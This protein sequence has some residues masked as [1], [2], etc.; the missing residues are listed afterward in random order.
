MG[1]PGWIEAFAT[2]PKYLCREQFSEND[3]DGDGTSLNV[4]GA[5]PLLESPIAMRPHYSK[6]WESEV[7]RKNLLAEQEFEQDTGFDIDDRLVT[8]SKNGVAVALKLLNL[9]S[10]AG[11]DQD[12]P[13]FVP[14]HDGDAI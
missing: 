11:S 4:L 2:D 1:E 3:L 14:L 5:L 8:N 9:I 13:V 7:L 10:A 6:A 12:C